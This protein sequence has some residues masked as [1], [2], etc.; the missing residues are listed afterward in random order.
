MKQIKT[1]ERKIAKHY[2]LIEKFRS[3]NTLDSDKKKQAILKLQML[4]RQL[5][6]VLN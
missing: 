2:K 1:I 3:D 5:K 4:I 6:W